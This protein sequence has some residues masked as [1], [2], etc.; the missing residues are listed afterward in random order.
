MARKQCFLCRGQLLE[1]YCMCSYGCATPHKA[2]HLL[3]R[4]NTPFF[5]NHSARCVVPGLK[6]PSLSHLLSIVTGGVGGIHVSE[7]ENTS[8]DWSGLFHRPQSSSS[9]RSTCIGRYSRVNTM[10]ALALRKFNTCN[11]PSRPS[12]RSGGKAE[13]TSFYVRV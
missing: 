10:Y 12:C 11:A 6:L 7:T 4:P 9:R 2:T 8:A 5:Q 1:V 13:N 3:S